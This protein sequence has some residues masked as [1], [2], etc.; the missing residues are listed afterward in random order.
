MYVIC[1][2]SPI[3]LGDE[4]INPYAYIYLQCI[5]TYGNPG[6]TDFVGISTLEVYS[7]CPFRLYKYIFFFIL[8]FAPRARRVRFSALVRKGRLYAGGICRPGMAIV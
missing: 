3:S 4:S 2:S 8:A 5:F 1:F 6:C 7:K